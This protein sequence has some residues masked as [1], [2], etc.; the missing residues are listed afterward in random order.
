MDQ[1]PSWQANSLS[2]SQEIPRPLWIPK[3]I[4][5]L[6]GNPISPYFRSSQRI[7]AIPKPCEMFRNMLIFRTRICK[8]TP[9]PKDGGPPLACC[10]L[11]LIQYFCSYPP[12]LEAIFP[13]HNLR[14]RPEVWKSPPP[15]PIRFH[16]TFEIPQ[17]LAS[18]YTILPPPQQKKI[19]F[20]TTCF[21]FFR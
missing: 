9:N 21:S 13:N 5:V 8:P 14:T 11:L 20:R 10:P 16:L 19:Y 12:F 18:Y 3:V 7:R 17:R 1:S 6:T 2:A 4:T 15:P